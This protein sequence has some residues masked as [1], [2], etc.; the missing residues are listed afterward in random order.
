MCFLVFPPPV[1]LL[2]VVKDE[3]L[4]IRECLAFPALLVGSTKPV[5]CMIK[6]MAFLF[7]FAAS[8]QS[9]SQER[10]MWQLANYIRRFFRKRPAPG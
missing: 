1:N 5:P 3:G 10:G 8:K 2:A 6:A 7:S 4:V 9:G